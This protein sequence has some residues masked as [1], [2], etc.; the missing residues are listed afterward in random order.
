MTQAYAYLLQMAD[1]Q[2]TMSL[3]LSG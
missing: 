3:R 1:G 2:I